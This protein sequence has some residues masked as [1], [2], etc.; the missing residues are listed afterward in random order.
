MEKEIRICPKCG[1]A[2]S[3]YP[4]I[5]RRDNITKICSNCGVEEALDDFYNAI[6]HDDEKERT[7]E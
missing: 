2:Y 3:D 6:K 1:R 4:A 7:E 5:S